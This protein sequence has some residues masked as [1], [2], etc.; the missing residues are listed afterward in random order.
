MA[1]SF[2]G[3]RI[4]EQRRI[5]TDRQFKLI[6]RRQV[7][8][9]V[10]GDVAARQLPDTEDEIA[11]PHLRVVGLKLADDRLRN[12]KPVRNLLLCIALGF[13]PLVKTHFEPPGSSVGGISQLGVYCHSLYSLAIYRRRVAKKY[14]FIEYPLFFMGPGNRLRELRKR[15]GLTQ[16]Q[17]A[18][19]T[20]VSQPTISELETGLQEM[21]FTW[22]RRFG[23]VLG[24]SAA[25]L[26]PDEDVP[27]RLRN[28]FERHL[29]ERAR[30]ADDAQRETLE[31]VAAAVIPLADNDDR[32]QAR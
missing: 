7:I 2:V 23:R 21:G 4:G 31:R 19:I 17:L 30:I 1:F 10:W 8:N 15:A 29:I 5:V 3:G 18:E 27:D 24:C 12:A 20:G 11:A 14:L 25:D 28:S 16:S 32:A 22:A 26:L 9:I 6:Y 13:A